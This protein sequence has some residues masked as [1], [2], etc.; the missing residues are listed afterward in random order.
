MFY[1]N[2][3]QAVN[4]GRT[5]IFQR[6]F[7]VILVGGLMT[8]IPCAYA[9]PEEPYDPAEPVNRFI[10]DVNDTLD[11][12]VMEPIARAYK[13]NVP[14]PVQIGIKNFFL[15][16]RYP[17]YLV[18]DI[19]QGK[20]E[21]ALDH[22]G[23]FLINSTIGVLGFIDFAKDYGL[24]D[25]EEDFGIALMHHGVPAGPYIVLPLLGPSNVRDGVGRIVDAF[26][27]PSGWIGYSSLSVGTKLVIAGTLFGVKAV[28]TRAGLL[29]AIEA[30]KESSVDYYL[31]A[32]GAYY[33]Y[34]QGVLTD[35]MD[36]EEDIG[37]GESTAESSAESSEGNEVV[38][39]SAQ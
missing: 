17:S 4:F 26:L 23:R 1:R 36:D 18:S 19:I 5:V 35:G 2:L 27:D 11:I 39:G 3:E 21:Q 38:T 31:F 7:A 37:G 20:F 14:D 28:H 33:Q 32:Q 15:N 25:H 9:A 30:G 12:H 13:N 16:L 24:P 6:I 10:F 22:T 8:A 29:Q 34:R